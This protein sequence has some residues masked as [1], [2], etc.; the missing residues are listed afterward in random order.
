MRKLRPKFLQWTV[1]GDT[2]EELTL[3]CREISGLSSLKS[4]HFLVHFPFSNCSKVGSDFIFL[5]HLWSLFHCENI[6]TCLIFVDWLIN[7]FFDL[8]VGVLREETTGCL[9][10]S[11]PFWCFWHFFTKSLWRAQHVPPLCT[12]SGWW[13][14][15]MERKSYYMYI[16]N[17]SGFSIFSPCYCLESIA[18]VHGSLA[19]V[20]LVPFQEGKK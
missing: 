6:F 17:K 10:F 19:C 7:L 4:S 15:E 9:R 14:K 11:S 3:L 5:Y 8:V 1:E 20:F 18:S 12:D 13:E 2:V 16:L